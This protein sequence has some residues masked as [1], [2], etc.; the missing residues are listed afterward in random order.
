MS[1]SKNIKK[2]SPQK[3][4]I[5]SRSD[6]PYAQRIAMQYKSD[7]AVNREHAAKVVLFCQSIAMN[8]LEHI[9]YK[10][11][12][13]FAHRY[14]QVE[15]EFYEDQELG[16]AHA[17]HR[18]KQMG[19]EIS[20]D[21]YSHKLDG[22]SKRTQGVFDHSM[23]AAQVAIICG[24]IAMNDE[25][26]FGP[27]RQYRISKRVDELSGEYNRK[28]DKFLLDK[29]KEIG[30]VVEN[31]RVMAFMDDNGNGVTPSKAIKEGYVNE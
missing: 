9:G 11:L 2:R 1:K 10:R 3:K 22:Q 25:F 12:I 17:M 29:M 31:G 16:M 7:V 5:M 27:E 14:S 30:F 8:E 24:A 23:Q 26:G 6:I 18:M 4:G 19:M 21:F 13:R 28:G 20:G 15:S